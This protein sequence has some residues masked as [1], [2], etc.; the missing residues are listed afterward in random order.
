MKLILSRKGMDSSFG[1]V[2]SPIMPDGRL[3]WLPIPEV[4]SDKCGLPLYEEVP[5]GGVTLGKLVQ[6]LSGG[7]IPADARA[8]LDPDLCADY[9]PRLPGWR[10]LFGQTG[11]AEKHLR[12]MGVGEGDIFLYFGWYRQVEE[13]DGIYRYV[14]GAP[15][16]HV[17]FGWLQIAERRDVLGLDGVPPW[18]AAHPHYIGQPYGMVDVV[19]V[20]TEHLV[21]EGRD[22][23]LPG[24]GMFRQLKPELVLSAPGKTRSVWRLPEWFFPR[25]GRKPLSYHEDVGRCWTCEDG[26]AWLQTAGRGQEFVLDMDH[27]PEAAAWVRGLVAGEEVLAVA[28]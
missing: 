20:G 22:T 1:P 4:N 9:R 11:S 17:L 15:D 6:D 12:N 13:V 19:Y 16:M 18:A 26:A 10:P 3:C 28:A 14:K 5:F 23:G 24:A 27:Y 7:K 25:E 21:L 8:H 2:A